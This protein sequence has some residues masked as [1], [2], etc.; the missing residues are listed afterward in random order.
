MPDPSGTLSVTKRGITVCCVTFCV[1][2]TGDA[3]VTV[4][5]SSRSPTASWPLTVAV[6]PVVSSTPARRSVENPARV[7]VTV[8]VPGRRFDDPIHA[9][10]VCHDSAEPFSMSA[11]LAASTVTPG[12]TAPESSRATP[13]IVPVA[14][15]WANAVNGSS[16][17]APKESGAGNSHSSSHLLLIRGQHPARAQSRAIRLRTRPRHITPTAA[18]RVSRGRTPAT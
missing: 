2:T 7:N 17:S 10:T 13:V 12:S 14:R 15:F 1:S 9:L 8:Y 4:I 16:K 18:K 6:N 3:P 5:V 11:G